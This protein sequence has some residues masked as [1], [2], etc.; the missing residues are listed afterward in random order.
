MLNTMPLGN[1]VLIEVTRE[2]DGVSRSDENEN[3]QQG[4][5][6]TWSID[7]YHLTASAAVRVD[8]NFLVAKV[9]E[10]KSM[11]GMSVRWEQYAEG[12]QTFVED[13]KTYALVPWWRLISVYKE[14]Q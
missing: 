2:Y 10:L 7:R 11:V 9:E 12:G 1:N 4:K 8:D 13:G 3:L 14:A 6:L 5:L